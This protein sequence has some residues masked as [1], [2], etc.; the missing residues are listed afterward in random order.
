MKINDKGY[1]D[2]LGTSDNTTNIEYMSK[3][4]AFRNKETSSDGNSGGN[5]E[6]EQTPSSYI[7][8]VTPLNIDWNS[9]SFFII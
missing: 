7:P 1:E 3:L 5:G 2:G 9:L 4:Y 6:P 8:G